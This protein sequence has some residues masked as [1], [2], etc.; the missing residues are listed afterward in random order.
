MRVASRAPPLHALVHENLKSLQRRA[1]VRS[2][3]EDFAPIVRESLNGPWENGVQA[4]SKPREISGE[5]ARSTGRM[6]VGKTKKNGVPLGR[7]V[8]C[9]HR[10]NEKLV[11][12]M[13]KREKGHFECRLF[14][15]S[16]G[17]L[18]L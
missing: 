6:T 10:G 9:V 13:R 8:V 18:S 17:L 15:F 12:G 16:S 11:E 7:G 2:S 14:L 1:R 4:A 3:R 5:A